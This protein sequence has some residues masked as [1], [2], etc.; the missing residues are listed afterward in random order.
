VRLLAPTPSA[1]IPDL[2][3]AAPQPWRARCWTLRPA[4]P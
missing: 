3:L 2:T 1:Q 4:W